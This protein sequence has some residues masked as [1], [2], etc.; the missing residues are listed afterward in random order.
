MATK[1]QTRGKE[2]L[3]RRFSAFIG[4]LLTLA[5]CTSARG[6][7]IP[8]EVA[9]KCLCGEACNQGMIGLMAVGEVIRTRDKGT[10]GVYGC[11]SDLYSRSPDYV[12]RQVREAWR[13]SATSNLTGRATNWENVKA[14]GKPYWADSMEKTVRIKDHQFYKQTNKEARV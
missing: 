5:V 12:K 6:E 7:A 3:N 11:K 8:D 2:G 14:F 1:Y 10:Q 13:K 4:A 9:Y